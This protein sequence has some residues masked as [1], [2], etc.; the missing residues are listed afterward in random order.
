MVC[1]YGRERDSVEMAR[2]TAR[3]TDMIDAKSLEIRPVDGEVYSKMEELADELPDSSPRF[4]L[5]S[6]PLTMVVHLLPPPPPS[7][8]YCCLQCRLTCQAGRPAVPYVLL[9]YLPENCNPSQR[10]SY[11]GAVELMRNTAEVNRVI[12]VASET[13]VIEIE[14]KLQSA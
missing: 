3:E 10:M 13:D 5:L 14:K 11:A 6:Y 7:L 2:L 4:I 9:Y 12:E 1:T 8:F